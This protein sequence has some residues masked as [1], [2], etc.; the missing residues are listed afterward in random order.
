MGAMAETRSGFLWELPS[1]VNEYVKTL[2][3]RSP[4][5]YAGNPHETDRSIAKFELDEFMHWLAKRGLL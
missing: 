2:D 3:A 1:L 4:S 5:I